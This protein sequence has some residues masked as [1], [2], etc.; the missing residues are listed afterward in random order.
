MSGIY[1]HIPFCKQKCHYCDFHF[2]VSLRNK[3][4]FIQALIKEIELRKTEINT[5]I[6]TIYLG[7]GTPSLLD[8]DELALIFDNIY[9][10]FEIINKP[11][12]TLEANPDDI[13]ANFI[14]DI[15]KQ[16]VNRLSIGIQSFHNDELAFMNRSHTSKTALNAIKIIQ[17]TGIENITI[18]L[19]YGIQGSNAERWN[20][21]L[22]MFRK[23]Q[24]PHLSAYA[25]TIEK[26]TAL[27]HFIKKGNIPPTDE[28]LAL[29]QFEQL[30]TFAKNNQL[31]HYELSNFAKEGFYAKHNSSYWLGN[32]Y[33]GFGPSAHSYNGEERSWNVAN[34]QKYIKAIHQNKLPNITETLQLK[35]KYNEYIMTRLR[36]IWGV[37]IDFISTAFSE[38]LLTHFQKN[39]EKYLLHRNILQEGKYYKIN[40]DAL[41]Y[42]DA[43]I[44]ELFYL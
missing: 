36:T 7:G 9:Q 24:I 5:P 43:I 35:D 40:P 30:R 37:D 21:N 42:S 17:N 31:I 28:N 38:H 19:I 18:D 33:W 44:A 32:K 39:V 10:H 26:K 1:I 22:E 25:L 4:D 12:I 6:E 14:K 27:F 2:A 8:Y 13:T 16:N 23:L 15:K 29:Q 41:F 3:K 34:N 11:E 20:Y